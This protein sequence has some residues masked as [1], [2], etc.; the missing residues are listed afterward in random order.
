MISKNSSKF[1]GHVLPSERVKPSALRCRYANRNR[2]RNKYSILTV[3]LL[4][5][6]EVD[7]AD[8]ES[9]CLES[10]VRQ[11]FI[12]A[13][14]QW[15]TQTL[16]YIYYSRTHKLR[17][18]QVVAK[19]FCVISSVMDSTVIPWNC[20]TVV[21]QRYR[22]WCIGGIRGYTPYTNLRDFWQRILTSVI[23]NKQGTFR[24]FAT[25][26]CVYPPPLAA[27]SLC[28][29][30]LERQTQYRVSGNKLLHY[31]QRKAASLLP[32]LEWLRLTWDILYILI[33]TGRC[34]QITGFPMGDPPPP[35][36]T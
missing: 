3:K 8:D 22:Q 9:K 32:R 16:R 14:F 26:L 6:S 4:D 23:I 5:T 11:L 27:G 20:T 29:T 17:Y 34:T 12:T 36:R 7:S 10:L 15:V 18:R 30:A 25:P 21:A 13:W 35:H 28:T 19:P 31:W 1:R 33:W 2:L 24:P